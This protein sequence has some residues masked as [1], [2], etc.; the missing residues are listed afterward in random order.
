MRKHNKKMVV[1]VN[2]DRP[3]TVHMYNVGMFNMVW[4][5][6]LVLPFSFYMFRLWAFDES[7]KKKI[8]GR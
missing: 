4:L 6:F 1:I 5:R 8:N 2:N 7:S 3:A